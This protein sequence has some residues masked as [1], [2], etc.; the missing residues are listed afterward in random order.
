LPASA[1]ACDGRDDDCDGAIDE[2]CPC[3]EGTTRACGQEFLTAPCTAGTQ[4]CEGARFTTCEG[5]V[6]PSA[7]ICGDS[8]DNDCNGRADDASLCSCVPVPEVCDNAIDDDCDGATDEPSCRPTVD[9]GMPPTDAGC[10]GTFCDVA[11]RPVAPLSTST[12]TSRRPTLRWE[13]PSGIAG[14]RVEL[15]ADR[16][17][18]SSLGTLDGATSVRPTSD[19]P[20][21]WVFWRLRTRVGT[22]LGTTVSPTW[23]F[24]VGAR[25]ADGDRDT[26][27]GSTLDLDGDGFAD[28]AV[29]V[30]GHDE[31]SGGPVGQ[32]LVFRGS[33]T[34]LATTPSWTLGA[35]SRS[36]LSQQGR[37]VL[38]VGD[39]DGD[40]FGDLATTS[41][42]FPIVVQIFRGGASGP[43]LG[44]A[45][46]PTVP[47]GLAEG[48]IAGLGDVDG[49]GYA[50]LALGHW[51][52]A[53]SSNVG[54]Y[55]GSS[56][57]VSTT[58][59]WV[60]TP[61][62]GETE[63][64]YVLG[65][66]GDVD[67]DGF[68]DLTVTSNTRRE[69]IGQLTLFR[70]SASGFMRAQTIIGVT[71]G[72]LGRSVSGSC[73]VDGDGFSDVVIAAPGGP[74]AAGVVTWQRGSASGW[75][76]APVVLGTG[77]S[78]GFDHHGYVVSC[79]PDLNG[80]GFSEVALAIENATTAGG[81]L[82]G[83]V[84]IRTGGPSGA[85]L[86]ATIDGATPSGAFGFALALLGDVDGDR[87]ADL[88]VGALENV[89]SLTRAGRA[90][91]FS[92]ADLGPSWAPAW[93]QSGSVAA[94]V[95]GFSV[96]RPRIP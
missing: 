52:G 51:S 13:L 68:A 20:T 18:A 67:A 27:W 9:G 22:A 29:G 16:A 55:R 53:L 62:P 70:G 56:A 32:V 25:S 61:E 63:F 41:T 88:A 17:C 96:G 65:D 54:I 35:T 80:D 90:Y 50:D 77:L 3:D 45:F 92:G 2:G 7:E 31:P 79:G 87:R 72:Q 49:D 57:G 64:G 11:P 14:A 82:T 69:P 44:P 74:G 47:D 81:A 5:G 26:S 12:V 84:E 8:V 89:G 48:A 66:A 94:D 46:E 1:E 38:S 75:S 93:T 85:T 28:L 24:W 40:G 34:G 4:R 15:C 33:S 76:A 86:A 23:Q 71:Y 42:A 21:G 37:T 6:F 10:T 39:L 95:L 36:R 19:L 59:A 73:D 83:R 58:S 78:G 43:S 91:V 30:P 60:L